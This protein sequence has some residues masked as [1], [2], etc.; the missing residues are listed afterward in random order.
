MKKSTIFCMALALM[1]M[2]RVSAQNVGI[3]TTHPLQKLHVAGGLRVDTLANGKDS[4]LLR[5]DADGVVFSLAF[6]GD[7]TQVLR[8]NGTFGTAAILAAPLT[9]PW[10]LG[11]NAG[12]SSDSNFLGTTDTAELR[13]RI[14]NQWAGE[15]DSAHAST[16][17]GYGAGKTS[18]AAFDNTAIGYQALNANTS[19]F[20]NTAVG[21]QALL[22]NNGT[23]NSGFGSGALFNNTSGNNNLGIG[24]GALFLNTT[25]S[26]N[27]AL[28]FQAGHGNTSGFS[29]VAVGIN[30]LFSNQTSSNTVAVGDSA[31]FH[32][33]SGIQN[34]AIGSKALF[35]D[36]AGSAN[37][38]VGFQALFS[39]DASNNTAVG[40][41]AIQNTSGGFNTA[42]GSSTLSVNT[43]GNGNVAVGF[44]AL[45]RN[46]TGGD[47]TAMGI[48]ALTNNLGGNGNVAIGGSSMEFS[49]SAQL[50]TAVGSATFANL[51]TGQQNTALGYQAELSTGDLNNATALGAGALVNASNKVRIGN[52][53]VTVI[54]GQVAFSHPSDGR[55]KFN[56]RE[57]V[58]GLDFIRRLRPIS[59]QFDVRKLDQYSNPHAGGAYTS[60]VMQASY[61]AAM[62]VRHT[63]FIAQEVEDA[64]QK[65]GYDF[66]GVIQPKN[67]QDH[68]S[69]NY[70]A[71]IM[72]LVKAI[73]EQQQEI[74]ELKKI[75]AA[76]QLLLK[77]Q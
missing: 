45:T 47:N 63:G 74:D 39:G 61:D 67:A 38:A 22:L 14:N 53:S 76:Q 73:Q 10:L 16:F 68:Y 71:F 17:F 33:A 30:S 12:T 69:L 29:N 48:V 72:P 26:S 6:S 34:T 4:G 62:A 11:G 20:A 32:Q 37:T 60:D 35:S 7:S 9:N 43:T 40:F 15:L 56:I 1:A 64:A 3:G 57:D 42:V 36:A 59:Y 31:L 5:H 58:K 24:P 19:G 27:T 23:F 41:E 46:T 21:Q 50:N 44:D 2:S 70:E 51:T 77:K 54:E 8:G 75:V 25:G 55:F 65:S 13:F 28:G 18:T 49:T 52:V 66:T